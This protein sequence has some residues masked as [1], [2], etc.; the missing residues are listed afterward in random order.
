M[1]SQV[2]EESYYPFPFIMHVKGRSPYFSFL[3][4]LPIYLFYLFHFLEFVS[5]LFQL[6]KPARFYLRRKSMSIPRIFMGFLEFDVFSITFIRSIEEMDFCTNVTGSYGCI[7]RC[8]KQKLGFST[9]SCYFL[10]SIHLF[11][12]F[13]FF[14]VILYLV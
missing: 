5:E 14:Q 1:L 2:R 3:N 12:P 4:S 8:K 10:L 13:P 7:S 9:C 6:I 11:S